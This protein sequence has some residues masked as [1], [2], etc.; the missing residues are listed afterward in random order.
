MATNQPLAIHQPP[1]TRPPADEPLWGRAA[2]LWLTLGTFAALGLANAA[3]TRLIKHLAESSGIAVDH[4]H[5]W[6]L[7][8]FSFRAPT[9]EV[10]LLLPLVAHR[11]HSDISDTHRKQLLSLVFGQTL[12]MQVIGSYFW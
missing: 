10:L 2:V 4:P 12:V 3:V 1:Q 6:P 5:I 8:V 11:Q 9:A 7:N